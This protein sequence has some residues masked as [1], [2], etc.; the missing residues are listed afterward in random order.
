MILLFRSLALA[1]CA[2]VLLMAAGAAH[3]EVITVGNPSFETPTLTDPSYLQIGVWETSITPWVGHQGYLLNKPLYSPSSVAADGAQSMYMWTG[4]PDPTN[5]PY[6]YQ[7]LTT[8]FESGQD[9]SLT[10]AATMFV[11]AGGPAAEGQTLQ[12][13]LGYWEDGQTGATG[14]TLVANR[15]IGST[16]INSAWQDYSVS[17]GVISADNPAVGKPIV[18]FVS[19]G[20]APYVTG[21]QYEFDNVRCSSVPEPST[22]ALLATGLIGLLGYARHKR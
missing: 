19:Q 21:P 22:I 13:S 1:G 8:N 10:L 15:L 5:R 18:I 9:Y 2:G 3:A 6:F 7:I 20:N 16:E 11:L 12:M 17:S 4:D 14:P